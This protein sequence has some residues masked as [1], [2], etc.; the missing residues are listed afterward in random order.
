MGSL[1]NIWVTRKIPQ[2]AIDMLREVADVEVWEEELPPPREV[3]LEKIARLDGILPLLTDKMDAVAMD[4]APRLRVIANYAVGYDNVDVPAATQRG[5]LVT[6]TPGV[7]TET[8]ADLA[9]ALLMAAARHVV[10]GD[11]Y[12][13]A[14]LWKTWGPLLF[15]GQDIHHANLG[16]VGLG[17]IGS[18]MAKRARGFDMRVRYY[19]PIRNEAAEEQ[20]GIEYASLE[21]VLRES[22]FV[23]LHT[24]LTAETRH[25]ISERELKMMKPTAILINS[26]RGPVVD[27]KAL[28]EALKSGTIYAAGLD[29]FDVEP[30]PEEDPL[31]TLDHVVAVPH[32]ASASYATRT[33][34]ATLAAENLIA[35]LKG[36]QPPTPVNPDVLGSPRRRR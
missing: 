8:T 23:S 28:Y 27:Q 7:L 30:I 15:L 6:N 36:E 14:G 35:A 11:K 10:A 25:L 17:R 24:P 26:S 4:R 3:V 33:R 31:L 1:G 34:M 12:T 21:T 18:E 20:L 5:I 9:F 13:R 2:K 32:I 16:L 29:V 19:D 22:D